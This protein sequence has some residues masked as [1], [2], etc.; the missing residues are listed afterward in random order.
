[1]HNRHNSRHDFAAVDR[2]SVSAQ[3]RGY[4][5]RR[6]TAYT[7][8]LERRLSICPDADLATVSLEFGR[9]L[10]RWDWLKQLARSA[11][12]LPILG[13]IVDLKCLLFFAAGAG[14]T[15]LATSQGTLTQLGL[16][17]TRWIS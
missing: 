8:L 9:R 12:R 13:A 1:M 3:L 10:H 16:K 5:D 14:S 2:R 11:T 17:F 7:R 4:G 6:E 15:W